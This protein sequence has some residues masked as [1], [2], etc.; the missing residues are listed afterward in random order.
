[1][2]LKN[3]LP[4]VEGDPETVNIEITVNDGENPVSGATVSIGNISSST[5]SQGG[6]TLQNVPEGSQTITVTKEGFTE[7]TDTITVSSSST[8]FTISLTAASNGG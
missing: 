8:S 4:E 7:Y 5:G 6:C 2:E 3:L 1:M